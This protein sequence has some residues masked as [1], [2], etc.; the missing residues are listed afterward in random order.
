[1]EN[2][3]VG[4]RPEDVYTLYAAI[5][6]YQTRQEFDRIPI[7]RINEAIKSVTWKFLQEVGFLIT[8]RLRFFCYD[9]NARSSEY[10]YKVRLVA[11]YLNHKLFAD[12]W[13]MRY[14]FDH[15]KRMLSSGQEIV[16][17][18]R[19]ALDCGDMVLRDLPSIFSVEH[20]GSASNS[21]FSPEKWVLITT[22]FVDVV[23]IVEQYGDLSDSDIIAIDHL[24]DINHNK[25]EL[26]RKFLRSRNVL[27]ALNTKRTG[28]IPTNQI[29]DRFIRMQ[30]ARKRGLR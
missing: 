21:S 11:E 27:K 7:H 25:G 29:G 8:D 2:R 23:D 14:T 12:N 26:I 28:D 22:A 6:V 3:N 17:C 30:Y 4:V 20:W 19:N 18:L 1:M 16:K 9:G 24:V 5:Y 13:G 15:A 10:G